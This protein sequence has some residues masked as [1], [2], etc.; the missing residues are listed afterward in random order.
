MPEL[1]GEYRAGDVRHCYADVRR[2][3]NVLGYRAAVDLDSGLMELAR[4]VDGRAVS[5]GERGVEAGPQSEDWTREPA[6]DNGAVVIASGAH[7]SQPPPHEG[8]HVQ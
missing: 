1:T 6:T 4:W 2:A 8:S 5:A 7:P 3:E